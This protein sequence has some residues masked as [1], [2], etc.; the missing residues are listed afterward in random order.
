MTKLDVG[1]GPSVTPGYVGLDKRDYG[2]EYVRDVR[3]GLP[4]DDDSAEM[5]RAAHFI[6]HLIHDEAL[7][8]LNDCWRVLERGGILKLATPHAQKSEGAFVFGHR[9]YYTESTFS[10]LQHDYWESHGIRR[11]KI[12]SLQT[13]RRGDIHCQMM[14]VKETT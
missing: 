8:F 5:I 6:E 12:L 13:N 2:R 9:S 3:N 1:C 11:W 14:P 10:D 7:A 4:F